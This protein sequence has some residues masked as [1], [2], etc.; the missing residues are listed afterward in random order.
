VSDY[1]RIVLVGRLGRDPESKVTAGGQA[2]C[3][4]SMATSSGFGDKRET[5]WHNVV[6]F[7]KQAEASASFLKKGRLC[8]V[9]GRVK[10]SKWTKPDGSIAY[11]T[12]IIADRVSFLDSDRSE[13][14][15]SGPTV[16]P[17]EFNDTGFHP[18]PGAAQADV[19][20]GDMPF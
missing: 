3:K 11:Q 5:D 18:A 14:R 4:F 8:L 2:I 7:G 15:P 19:T 17:G 13:D 10:Y 20:G 1:N 9:E 6:V 16:V 12:D